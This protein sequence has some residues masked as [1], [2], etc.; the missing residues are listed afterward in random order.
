M[1]AVPLPAANATTA[2][3]GC[4]GVTTGVSTC[5]FRCNF[6]ASTGQGQPITVTFVGNPGGKV[7]ASCGGVTV[8][9]TAGA[10]RTC[11][12]T[13]GPVSFSQTMGTCTGTG[14]GAFACQTS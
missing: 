10:T 2:P 6:N 9:C 7:T 5:Y 8:S 3:D 12:N 4:E 14:F 13:G 11:L 1:S